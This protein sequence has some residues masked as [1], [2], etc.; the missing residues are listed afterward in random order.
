MK[1]LSSVELEMETW[2]CALTPVNQFHMCI[3]C[4]EYLLMWVEICKHTEG[5]SVSELI[6]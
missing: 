6:F 1:N 2:A 3:R 5:F 4:A